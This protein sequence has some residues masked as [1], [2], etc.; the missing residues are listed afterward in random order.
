MT[1]FAHKGPPRHLSVQVNTAQQ[2]V[3]LGDPHFITFD[4]VKYTFNGKGEYYRVDSPG[5]GLR[6]QGQT[7]QVKLENGTLAK[8][9]SPSAVTIRNSV[10][11]V[12]QAEQQDHLAVFR[13]QQVLSFT[14]Q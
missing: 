7:E 10:I 5:R 4:C 8:A 12:H 9:N 11:E 1:K 2:G 13:N 6:I 3:V 14:E